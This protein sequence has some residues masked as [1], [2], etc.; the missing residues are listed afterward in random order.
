MKQKPAIEFGIIGLGTF[1]SNLAKKLSKG[2]KTP[3]LN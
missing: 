1:G 2:S 3:R